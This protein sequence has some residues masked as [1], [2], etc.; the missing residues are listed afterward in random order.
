MKSSCF[1]LFEGAAPSENCFGPSVC[2]AV[3]SSSE[4]RLGSRARGASTRRQLAQHAASGASSLGCRR[5]TAWRHGRAKFWCP[6][7]APCSAAQRLLRVPLCRLQSGSPAPKSTLFPG[8]SPRFRGPDSSQGACS[9]EHAQRERALLEFGPEL[10]EA[11]SGQIFVPPRLWHL[12]PPLLLGG[13]T[14]PDV[15]TATL[16]DARARDVPVDASPAL[17]RT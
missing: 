7:F 1:F 9:A 6:A 15:P 12:S 14:C 10:P 16:H 17:P 4:P 3:S 11:S 5:L 8:C 13:F 2:L